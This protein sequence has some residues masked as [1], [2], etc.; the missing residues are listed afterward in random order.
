LIA[1]L[2]HSSWP[3]RLLLGPTKHFHVIRAPT[4][5]YWGAFNP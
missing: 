1:T 3:N 2:G 4:H 5:E